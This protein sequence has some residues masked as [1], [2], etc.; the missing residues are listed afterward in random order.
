MKKWHWIAIGAVL[1]G[2]IIFASIKGGAPPGEKVYVEAVKRRDLEAIVSAPGVIQPKV[3]VNISAHVVGKIERLYFKEGDT[4]RKGQKL[5]ELE[6]PNFLAQ[7]D[8]TLAEVSNRR[9]EVNR[10]RIALANSEVQY[11][12]AQKLLEQGIQAQELFE[13]ARL[14]YENAR[15]ALASAE[16]QVEQ[17]L[18][19]LRQS[20]EDLFRATIVAPIDGRVVELSAQEGEV[21]ITGTMNNPGSVIA[22][23][24]DLSEIL[25]EADVGETEVIQIRAGQGVKV[26]VDAVGDK[27]YRGRVV[28]IGSS[29]TTRAGSGSGIRYFKVKVAV[30]DADERL[31]P[32]MTAQVE[33]IT[34]AAKGALSVP[35]QSVVERDP[36][37]L[38]KKSKK[39]PVPEDEDDDSK[40]KKKYVFVVDSEKVRQVE[41]TTGISTAT[42]VALVSGLKEG[43]KVV[44]GPFRTL[45][46]LKAD[47]RV[48]PEKEQRRSRDSADKEKDS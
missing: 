21:V 27:E 35:V 40:P 25:V 29:A 32:G 28:E 3:K 44:T 38:R 43:E 22:V 23:I 18:A 13:R 8:R 9:I 12:R 34:S 6:K 5:V 26:K 33:I 16:Q 19:S 17:G 20:S 42:H 37:S 39:E 46:K 4:V 36:A 7:R 15:A 48:Q 30:E 14:E 47:D 24:A 1:L 11:R 10:A 41:V 31:R 45:R 2:I